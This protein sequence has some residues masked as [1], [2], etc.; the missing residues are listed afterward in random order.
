MQAPRRCRGREILGQDHLF[1]FSFRMKSKGVSKKGSCFTVS[2]V[3][4]LSLASR[5]RGRNHNIRC[6][7]VC[8]DSAASFLPVLI[9]LP[10]QASNH[11]MA[12]SVTN[13]KYVAPIGMATRTMMAEKRWQKNT[14]QS[15]G[16]RDLSH[17]G[18]ITATIYQQQLVF[19]QV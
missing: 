19:T 14:W 2:L 17:I 10:P 15:E 6:R 13:H 11:C 18:P 12:R 16:V 3:V 1:F 5:E 9:T 7:N 8:S 4:V